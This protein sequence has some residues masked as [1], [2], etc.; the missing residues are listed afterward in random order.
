MADLSMDD[1][2]NGPYVL[3]ECSEGFERVQVDGTI[4]YYD[5]DGGFLGSTENEILLLL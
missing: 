5:D 1:K 3:I 4:F 2:D